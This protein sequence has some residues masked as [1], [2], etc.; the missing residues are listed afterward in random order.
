M[1]SQLNKLHYFFHY[2]NYPTENEYDQAFSIALQL[3]LHLHIRLCLVKKFGPPCLLVKLRSSYFFRV[4][5]RSTR[6]FG[7]S[8]EHKSHWNLVDRRI[9]RYSISSHHVY[10]EFSHSERD[11]NQSFILSSIL[12]LFWGFQMWGLIWTDDIWSILY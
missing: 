6:F 1:S 10:H 8:V 5:I 7:V 4:K 12:V 11:I 9:F 2:L 3:H